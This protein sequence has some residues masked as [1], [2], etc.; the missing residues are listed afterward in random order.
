VRRHTESEDIIL[1]TELLKF[2]R[3]ITLIA[4]KDKQLASPNYL[5][6]CMLDKVFQPLN[7]KFVSC[8]AVI[9]NCDSPV[10]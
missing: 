8:L 5:V 1:L 4:I 3:L 10:S 2:K 9:T 7:S 6:L